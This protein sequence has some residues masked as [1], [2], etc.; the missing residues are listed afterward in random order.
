MTKQRAK[1]IK[2][3]AKKQPVEKL[4][5]S[6]GMAIHFEQYERAAIIRSVIGEN[7][8]PIPYDVYINGVIERVAKKLIKRKRK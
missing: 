7:I 3:W 1:E 2:K 5:A 8:E 4:R 6:L